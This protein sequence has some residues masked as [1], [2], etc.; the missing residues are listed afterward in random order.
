MSEQAQTFEQHL[1]ALQDIVDAL[2][3]GDLALAASMERYSDGVTRLKTCFELL[4][5]AEAQVKKLVADGAG[6]AAEVP[7]DEDAEEDA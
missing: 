2:E 1:E 4:K 3:S 5:G 7:F 6:G